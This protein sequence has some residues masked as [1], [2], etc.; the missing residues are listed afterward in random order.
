MESS[1]QVYVVDFAKAR[2]QHP[3][4]ILSGRSEHLGKEELHRQ[5]GRVMMGNKKVLGGSPTTNYS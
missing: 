5:G 2:K 3:H 4:L 1:E